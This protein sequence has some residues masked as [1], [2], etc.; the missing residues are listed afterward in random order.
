MKRLISFLLAIAL[1]MSITSVAFAQE[2]TDLPNQ[3]D[4]STVWSYLDD[5]TDPSGNPSDEGYNRTAWTSVDFDDS[6][7]KTGRGGFGAENGGEY[8]GASVTLEG[9]QGDNTNYPTYYFRT[10]INVEKA[11]IVTAITGSI[12]Y[13][14]AAI[15]YINGVKVAAFNEEGCDSN[16]SYATN[17][18]NRTETFEITD[19]AALNALKDGENV[20]AVEIHN[21]FDNSSDIWFSMDK[22]SFSTFTFLLGGTSEWEYL[23][24]NTDP[25]GDVSESGYDRTTWTSEN[26]NTDG[27]KLAAGP[28]GSNEGDAK[29]DTIRTAATVLDGCDG[30]N[31]TPSYFFRTT[32]NINNLERYTMLVG[33]IEYDDGIIVYINGQ[34]VAEGHDIAR[35]ENG[36]SL[37]H[38]FDSNLQY[39]GS[40]QGPETLDFTLVDLSMLHNGENTIAVEIHN[41]SKTSPDIWFSCT[42]LFLFTDEVDYQN[43][44]SLSVGAFESQINFTWYSPLD[45]ASVTISENPDMTNGKVFDATSSV[46]NDEQYSCQATATDLKYDTTYYYQLNNKGKT[47]EIYSFSTGKEGEFSFALVGDP[48]IGSSGIVRDDAEWENVLNTVTESELFSD[49]SFLISAGDQ[50]HANSEEEYDAYLE[51]NALFGLPVAT[52]VGNHDDSNA[53]AQHFNVPNESE[54]Y[55]VTAAGGDYYFVYNNTLFLV[56]NSN[57]RSQEDVEG[58]KAFMQEA[59]EETKNRE[60]SWKVAVFH[61]SIFTVASHAHDSYIEDEDGFKNM[62]IPVLEELDIDTVFMGHDHVYCRTYIMDGSEPVTELESY[63]Y[64]DGKEAPT[65]VTDPEG[66]L[67]ITANSGSG[68]KHYDILDESFPFSAVQNQEYTANISKITVSD[69]SFS[70]TTYRVSDMS[71]ID[72]FTIKKTVADTPITEANYDRVDAAIAKAES[73]NKDDYKDFSAV[74][75]AINAVVRGLDVSEQAQVDAMAEAIEEAIEN[76]EKITDETPISP[77]IPG[78]PQQPT[79]PDREEENLPSQSGNSENANENK[80]PHT[81]DATLM[82]LYYAILSVSACALLGAITYGR[83]KT[84]IK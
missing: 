16:N 41:S 38:G 17:E 40:D 56:L 71:V 5:N 62:I 20:I 61:H 83:K 69:N 79:E 57:A 11:S 28:F 65:A 26:F 60:I 27:W 37:G 35:D 81:S 7:W 78:T 43:N 25:S 24:D 42:G 49:I 63:E 3:I 29:Y 33:S 84:H 59:I 66:I 72:S 15:I 48:Q 23:D 2:G 13:D 77:E 67:Y 76:L 39:G 12:S 34:R 73:L 8:G 52:A 44:I 51:H 58:H 10:K 53:Y 68:S 75:A 80:P 21:H 55:G 82:G 14:D 6:E 31:S 1:I 36:E 46:T 4:R 50:V 74:E 22:L 70:I 32:F 19:S 18:A 30:K 47:G 64:D 9:C 45:E 54:E